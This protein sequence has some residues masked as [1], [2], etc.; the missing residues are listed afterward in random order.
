MTRTGQRPHKSKVLRAASE[1]EASK[2]LKF[3]E[4]AKASTSLK[5]AES[6]IDGVH[7]RMVSGTKKQQRLLEIRFN[8]NPPSS[9]VPAVHNGSIAAPYAALSVLLNC[10]LLQRS[11]IP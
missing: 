1:W 9:G 2:S 4:S 11:S 8:A 5:F 10:N 6:A 7:H 3:A